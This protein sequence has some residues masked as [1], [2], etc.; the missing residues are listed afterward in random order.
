VEEPLFGLEQF[1]LDS[2]VDPDSLPYIAREAK[3][4]ARLVHLVMWRTKCIGL[5][6]PLRE[7]AFVQ[8]ARQV[9]C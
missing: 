8:F 2:Y 9:T 7:L 6:S 5:K 1:G 3:A 4:I